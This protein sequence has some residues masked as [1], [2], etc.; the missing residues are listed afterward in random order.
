MS[1]R[2][3][4]TTIVACLAALALLLGVLS[5]AQADDH[6]IY[7]D[8][9]ATGAATGLSWT[10]AFTTVQDALAVAQPGDEIWVAEG[11]YYPDEGAG[12]TNNARASTFQ[13]LDGVALY[14]GFAGT[15]TG[16][17]SGIGTPTS[18]SLAVTSTRTT[19]W[20]PTAWSPTRPIWWATTP[21]PW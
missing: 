11:V 1:A 14:G 2:R 10:N 12:Q 17:S 3:L 18:L 6:I 13:L 21:T 8:A 20:T 4:P 19:A 16:A 15:E 9:D 7:V 5:T